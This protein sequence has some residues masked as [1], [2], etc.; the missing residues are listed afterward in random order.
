MKILVVGGGLVGLGTARALRSRFPAAH[1]TVV[2]KEP[3]FGAHQSTHNSG[4]LHCG[5]YYRP[6]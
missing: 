2:D 5:L 6:G 3:R 4:V 1:L